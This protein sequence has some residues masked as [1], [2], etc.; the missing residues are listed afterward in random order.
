MTRRGAA[1]RPWTT[2]EIA[3]LIDMAGRLSKREICRQLRRSSA[4]VKTMACRLDIS[5]RC[6][7]ARLVWCD[8]C[9]TY[10]SHLDADGRCRICRMRDQLQGREAACADV[11][12]AM[13]P[14]DRRIYEDAETLRQT[15]R[16]PPK[17]RKHE[18]CP[19]SRYERAKAESRHLLDLEEWEWYCLKLR[20]DAAKTRLRRMREKI[21]SNPRKNLK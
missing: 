13:K 3:S 1:Q 14:E 8:E 6:Y 11:M 16:M 18:S 20:Y 4:S 15:R 17:P 5:L 7:K 12:D 19:M 2:E 10:R 9:A 21:G